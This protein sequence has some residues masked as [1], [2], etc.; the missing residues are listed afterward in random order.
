VNHTLGD[1]KSLPGLQI[2]GPVFQV[3]DEV[4]LEYE[5]EFVVVVV[6]VPVIFALQDTQ[7]NNRII[8]LTQRL[9]VPAVRARFD[10]CGNVNQA[11]GRK[12]DVEMR[13]IW[14]A[15]WIAHE[16]SRRGDDN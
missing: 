14:E 6:L 3:D 2:N 11:E 5:E 12:L 16:D 7:S 10:K 4:P 9:V 13:R 1:D 8:H 15:F